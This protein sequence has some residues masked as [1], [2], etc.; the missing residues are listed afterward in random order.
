[1]A[2]QTGR[3]NFATRQAF[4]YQ[5]QNETA[6]RRV[7]TLREITLYSAKQTRCSYLERVLYQYQVEI[8]LHRVFTL[9]GKHADFDNINALFQTRTRI[10]LCIFT[11]R[12][13]LPEQL[14]QTLSSCLEVPAGR[15]CSIALAVC[16]A[17]QL[18]NAPATP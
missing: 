12:T 18:C 1:M 13:F 16:N 14:Q 3:V 8:A 11:R 17:L 5:S 9:S 4:L 7:L 10:T 6:R 15:H 2:R